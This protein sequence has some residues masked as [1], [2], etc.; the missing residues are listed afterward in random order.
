M[1]AIA[2]VKVVMA[3]RRRLVGAVAVAPSVPLSQQGVGT[4]SVQVS[5]A[6][7]SQSTVG[8]AAE[9]NWDSRPGVGF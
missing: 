4:K 5:G 2:A 3:T 6:W 8:L 9:K 7:Y 1:L